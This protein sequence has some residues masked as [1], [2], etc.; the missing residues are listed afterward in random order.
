M[1]E[2]A[3]ITIPKGRGLLPLRGKLANPLS[4]IARALGDPHRGLSPRE[5]LE[6]LPPTPLDWLTCRPVAGFHLIR[7]QVGNKLYSSHALSYND[8]NGVV[9]R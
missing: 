7:G 8:T 6:D 9:R 4:R 5:Q 1:G 2:G 3:S